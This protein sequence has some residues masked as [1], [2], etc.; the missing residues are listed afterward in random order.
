M[1]IGERLVRKITEAGG[2]LHVKSALNPILWMCAIV[3]IPCVGAIALWYR[4]N[5]PIWLIFLANAPVFVGLF[6]FLFLL[7]F[8]RDKLQSEDYQIRKQSLELIQEKGDHIPMSVTSVEA[9][10]N[11]QHPQLPSISNKGKK[12]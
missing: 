4:N 6:G 8:D 10:S 5:P 3:T 2:R 1:S 9:I 12:E 7:F 11:P